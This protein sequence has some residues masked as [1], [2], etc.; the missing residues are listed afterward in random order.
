ML[1]AAWS[2]DGRTIATS[3]TDVVKT[4]D[5]STGEQKKKTVTGFT[6]GVTAVTYAGDGPNVVATCGDKTLKLVNGDGGNV[7]KTFSGATDFLYAVAV[8][9]NGELTAGGQD[10]TLRVW[11]VDT[12]VE[13]KNFP[14]P[15]EPTN[16]QANAGK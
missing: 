15:T 16:E 3:S 10:G 6:K 11:N 13:L 8:S 14:V 7:L 5:L 4:W 1:G 9:A 2:S 12:A